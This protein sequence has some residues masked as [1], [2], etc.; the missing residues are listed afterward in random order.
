MQQSNHDSLT[1]SVVVPSFNSKRTIRETLGAILGQQTK[2]ALEVIV[3]DSSN[4]GTGDIIEKEFPT[5]RLF[6]LELR[7][8]AKREFKS[9]VIKVKSASTTA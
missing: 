8:H 2:H 4:D 5:V 7:I 3:V 6:R 9:A 1:I